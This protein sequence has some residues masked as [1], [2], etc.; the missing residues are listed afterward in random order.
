MKINDKKMVMLAAIVLGLGFVCLSYAQ[1]PDEEQ[2][3]PYEAKAEEVMEKL[4]LSPEQEAKIKD[5]QVINREKAKELHRDLKEKRKELGVELEKPKFDMAK[6]KALT[7][8]LTEIEGALIEHR[9][10]GAIKMRELLTSE[11]Y[12]TFTDTM[13]KVHKDDFGKKWRKR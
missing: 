7:Q 1:P 11:Q 4:N 3:R 6:I 10:N 9:V 12:Q 8:D 5:F 13:K 2:G